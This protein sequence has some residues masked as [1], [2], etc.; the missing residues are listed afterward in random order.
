MKFKY[1]ELTASWVNSAATDEKIEQSRTYDLWWY[2]LRSV[3]AWSW[4][5]QAA[6]GAD[7]S[8]SFSKNGQN[9]MNFYMVL[10][11]LSFLLAWIN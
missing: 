5:L 8:Y 9:I 2:L 6:C 3:T 10:L 1:N 4:T 7:A 11:E